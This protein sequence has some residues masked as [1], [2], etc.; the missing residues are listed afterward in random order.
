[1]SYLNFQV[2]DFI[3][4][5]DIKYISINKIKNKILITNTDD[6]FKSNIYK[7]LCIHSGLSKIKIEGITYIPELFI[8][9]YASWY[10]SIYYINCENYK[11]SKDDI[12][13]NKDKEIDKIRN[14][15]ELLTDILKSV[16]TIKTDLANIQTFVTKSNIQ[17]D[18]KISNDISDNIKHKIKDGVQKIQEIKDDIFEDFVIKD[19]SKTND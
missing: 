12:D 2:N 6:Y 4:K 5:N 11:N 14:T 15:N 13:K 9:S 18:F 7:S 1:M 16:I 19:K 8:N 10:S 17:N 3:T